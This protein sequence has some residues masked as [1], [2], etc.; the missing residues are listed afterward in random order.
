[1]FDELLNIGWDDYLDV[2]GIVIVEWAD[3]S[4]E[5]LPEDAQWFRFSIGEDG[6]RNIERQ[7]KH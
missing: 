7:D 3:K 4:P 1:M 2:Q 6:A 5:L